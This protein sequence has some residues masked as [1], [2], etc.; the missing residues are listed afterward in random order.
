M[1]LCVTAR[2]KIDRVPTL[3]IR[4]ALGFERPRREARTKRI[5]HKGDGSRDAA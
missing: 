1:T 4:L 5:L 3:N 2:E